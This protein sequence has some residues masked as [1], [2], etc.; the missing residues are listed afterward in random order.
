[1]QRRQLLGKGSLR[2]PGSRRA[3]GSGR[4]GG[5]QQSRAFIPAPPSK[6]DDLP[7]RQMLNLAGNCPALRPA[8][9]PP[10]SE[11]RR[12]HRAWGPGQKHP[13]FSSA[14]FLSTWYAPGLAQLLEVWK[15]NNLLANPSF[16]GPGHLRCQECPGGKLCNQTKLASPAAC[17]PGHYCPARGLL[18]IPCPRV[19][20]SPPPFFRPLF[21]F[22]W[23]SSA[24]I[25][26]SWWLGRTDSIPLPQHAA[27]RP[28]ASCPHSEE[29]WA[30]PFP[31]AGF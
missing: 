18:S 23:E 30:T 22:A 12:T 24:A 13:Q 9:A 19:R 31:A 4:R 10:S 20:S 7:T 3:L 2:G 17:P 8:Q 5:G 28:S 14:H 16:Q 6:H 21:A 26:Q 25:S 1:M 15:E 29:G 11:G 27:P